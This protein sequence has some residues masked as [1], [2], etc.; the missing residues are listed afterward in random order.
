MCG[1][2][3]VLG[4]EDLLEDA[5]DIEEFTSPIEAKF[6]IAPTQNIYAILT[7]GNKRKFGQLK[8]GL[9]PTWA[10]DESMAS[11]MINA[12]SET[13]HEK[14]SFSSAFKKRRCLIPA[15]G[16]YEWKPGTSS[17]Q[18]YFI[19]FKDRR[20]FAFA[21]LWE[22][23]KNPQTGENVFTGTIL[24]TD[25][26]ELTKSVHHRMPVILDKSDYEKWLDPN[27]QDIHSLKQMLKPLESQ[28]LT[29]YPVSIEVNKV[30][31]NQSYLIEPE[32]NIL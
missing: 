27:F 11:K 1:R 2:Y 13:A 10:K 15:I 31:N 6:N 28:D 9:I 19:T 24:T 29:L 3:A 18:P 5:F 8:W 16:Y 23:W 17:K 20:L 32:N 26:N 4:D 21:G 22:K 14:P 25:S 12:R 7:S 30:S